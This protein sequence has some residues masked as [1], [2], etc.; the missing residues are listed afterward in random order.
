M[1]IP[2]DCLARAAQ[3]RLEL[4]SYGKPQQDHH[5][6]TLLSTECVWQALTTN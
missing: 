3:E 2:E 1:M 6:A 4:E 5:T